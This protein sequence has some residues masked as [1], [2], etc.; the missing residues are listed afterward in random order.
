[1]EEYERKKLK[2]EEKGNIIRICKDCWDEKRKEWQEANKD[3]K[4]E[5]SQLVKIPLSDGKKT[6]HLWVEISEII[7]EMYFGRLRNQPVDIK[8]YDFGDIISFKRE[9][10]EGLHPPGGKK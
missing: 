2:K 9:H 10:V 5:I 7:G 1:M 6:E 4:L 8:G 3:I